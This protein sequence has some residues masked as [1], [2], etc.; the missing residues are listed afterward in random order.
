ELGFVDRDGIVDRL[1]AEELHHIG[2]KRILVGECDLDHAIEVYLN[3]GL[4]ELFIPVHIATRMDRGFWRLTQKQRNMVVF[5]IILKLGQAQ[6]VT[7][8][9]KSKDPVHHCSPLLSTAETRL[10]GWWLRPEPN[11]LTRS[12][13]QV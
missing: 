11:H 8:G 2:E 3:P 10:V 9:Q 6:P 12:E 5:I 1:R 13:I 4:H 7:L